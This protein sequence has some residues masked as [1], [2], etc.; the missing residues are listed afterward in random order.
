VARVIIGAAVI[1]DVAGLI[2]LAVAKGVATGGAL[3][4]ADLAAVVAIALGFVTLAIV[5]GP[6]IVD[7]AV[8]L[9]TRRSAGPGE[10]VTALA[11]AICLG[12]SALAAVFGLAA[13]VGAFF[14][15]MSFA[16]YRERFHLEQAFRPLALLLTPV[17]FAFIGLQLDIGA[18]RAAI[19][20]AL[21][22]TLL[23][24]VTKWLPCALAA[25]RMGTPRAL[26]VGAG[27][28]PR[29]EVGIIVALV[30]L[31]AGIVTDQLYAIVVTMALLTTILGPP[32]L[33]V[34]L[35]RVVAAESPS[36]DAV[37]APV[38]GRS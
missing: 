8:R 36:A 25:R 31:N 14:A 37:P 29:G 27:M 23:A 33:D 7:T 3:D 30:G 34:L 24:V 5:L 9:A 4:L 13:L 38:T 18:A 19:G 15:G 12:L 6:R 11:I 21:L 35:R 26:A 28:I 17:F 22:V 16:A 10:G 32:L 20:I 1:D 2:V